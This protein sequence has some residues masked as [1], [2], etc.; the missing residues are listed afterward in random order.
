M[1]T[2]IKL[3]KRFRSKILEWCDAGLVK[4]SVLTYHFNY[5]H[6]HE[7]NSLYLCLD[8]PSVRLPSSRSNLVQEE[9]LE[10]IPVEIRNTIKE[11]TL[12]YLTNPLLDKLEVLDYEWELI[13]GKASRVYD[14][15]PIEEIFRFS[16]KGTGI[17]LKILDNN[18]T[19]N[20]TWGTDGKIVDS[21]KNRIQDK[22]I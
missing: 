21:I 5:P 3:H 9:T 4:R 17:A 10:Q 11:T 14:N 13:S 16:S 6:R 15:A 18:K 22:L 20:R 2:Q 8:V 19:R 12:Q 7:D 1:D